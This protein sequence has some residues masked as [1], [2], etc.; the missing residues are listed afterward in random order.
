VVNK[1]SS[2][3]PIS[4][5]NGAAA[6]FNLFLPLV[7]VRIISPELVGR[8]KI[9]FLYVMLSPGLFMTAG[10]SN[11]LYHW[12]GRYPATKVQVRQSWTLLLC[13]S[14][15]LTSFVWSLSS[16]IAPHLQMELHDLRMFL[17]YAPMGLASAFI[18]D[19]LIARGD[20]WKGSLYGSGFHVT[21]ALFV[22]ATAYMTRSV[23]NVLW[24]FL[25]VTVLRVTV[26]C[27]L[28]Y[29]SGDLTPC[30][31][32]DISRNVL[33]YAFP[34]S[35]AALAGLALSNVDQM[36]LSFKLK[37]AEFAFYA[38][39]CLSVPPLQILEMSVNRVM[40]PKLSAAFTE[41][42]FHAAATLYREAVSELFRFLLPAA[43]GLIIFA[44]PIIQILFTERY[45][46]ASHYL[47][48]YALYYLF[49]SIPYDAVARS[50][51]DGLWILRM[52]LILAPLAI[53]ATWTA[54]THFGARG[55]LFAF[56][57]SQFT[58]RVY[59]LRYQRQ[60][61]KVPFSEF[62]P[63]K[64]MGLLLAWV[65]TLALVCGIT[66]P[67]F[68]DNRLWFIVM[69]PLFT[70]AYF[71]GAFGFVL[72]LTHSDGPIQVLEL[73]QF[74]NVGGL[75]KMVYT[76][77]RALNQSER[78]RTLVATYDRLSDD[79]GSLI[80][81]FKEAGIPVLQWEKKSGFSPR[82][83]TRLLQVSLSEHKRILHAHDL[84]P[85]IYGSI[86][87]ALSLGRVQLVFTLH[88][89]LHAQRSRRY[90]LYF[91]YFLRFADRVIAVSP[92]VRQ[93]LIEIGIESHR[94]EIV[95]NGVSFVSP[96]LGDEKYAIK[97]RLL[98][99]QP[100]DIY[101]SRWILSLARL[102]EG[103]GQDLAL[104]VW[105]ELPENVRRESALM[106]VGPFTQKHFA[107]KL[108]TE[109]KSLPEANR[110]F[111]PGPSTRPEEWIRASHVFFSGSE[112]EGMPLAPLEAVGSGLPTLLS[113]IPGHN[114]LKPWC[115]Y[116]AL[117]RPN[118]GAAIILK[119]FNSMQ[120]NEAAFFETQWNTAQSL[121]DKWN[122]TAMAASYMD[123][124][125]SMWSGAKPE[126]AKNEYAPQ[127]L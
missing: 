91:K 99:G 36:L 56:L 106:L 127:Y 47:Q 2:H 82:I 66:R 54:A 101:R 7:L 29:R 60:R 62:L 24:A 110:V 42:R 113:D 12:A 30:F 118:E 117:T 6:L 93:G 71:A 22:L 116:F 5:T 38:M 90:R 74:L 86:V 103:K 37:P 14:L 111:L 21:R 92:A 48:F 57:G 83:V 52:T 28:V 10:L 61:L 109:I 73:V 72:R 84:G 1:L 87:K 104:K 77:S 119:L 17:L 51:G 120:E 23:E 70:I 43:A 40:I 105:R 59:A 20:I 67:L 58:L 31:S 53:A 18:E 49:M 8:Y 96:V 122:E 85:L 123:L 65:L 125:E 46:A 33:K 76:L 100:N 94:I 68:P 88:T 75:E 35:L 11:G 45:S 9:F 44:H 81:Q 26:G 13:I 16:Y 97:R 41:G 112:H 79:A 78:F 34:V 114:F 4:L 63:F 89:L 32:Q 27:L 107:D 80:P 25:A 121:R 55:A 95:P 69:G 102:H 115:H 15:I 108:A 39:G 98:P 3:W 50:I 19:L 64:Q 126:V 124:F